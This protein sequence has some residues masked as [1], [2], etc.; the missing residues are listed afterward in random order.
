MTAKWIET[1]TSEF[2]MVA[3]DDVDVVTMN[4][5]TAKAFQWLG[6]KQA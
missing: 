4:G 1:L 3:L 6:L 2:Y 5:N